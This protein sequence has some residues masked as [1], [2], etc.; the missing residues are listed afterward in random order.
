MKRYETPS[1]PKRPLPMTPEMKDFLQRR[2]MPFLNQ[3][4]MAQ[5]LSHL[6]EEVYLQGM[7]DAVQAMK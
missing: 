6:L 1:L 2:T 3:A 5:P 4:G 7:R